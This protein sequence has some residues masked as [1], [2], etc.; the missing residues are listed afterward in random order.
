MQRLA[1]VYTVLNIKWGCRT[2]SLCDD[3]GYWRS[4][5]AKAKLDNNELLAAKFEKQLEV[6]LSRKKYKKELAFK[7]KINAMKRWAIKKLDEII[8]DYLIDMETIPENPDDIGALDV[9]LFEDDDPSNS[10]I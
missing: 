5:I 2:K 9:I 4:K 1:G 8:Q 6:H 10:L 7:K 3:R